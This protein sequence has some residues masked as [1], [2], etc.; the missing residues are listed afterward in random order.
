MSSAL[1]KF[2]PTLSRTK[3]TMVLIN[4]VRAG[5]NKMPTYG[6]NEQTP[7][8]KAIPFYA[9]WRARI[10]NGEEMKDKDEVIGNIIKIKNVKN[11]VGMPKR[12]AEIDLYYNTGFNPNNEYLDFT[13]DLGLV[14]RK[15]SWFDNEKWGLHVQG[16]EKLMDF[17]KQN[18]EVFN[19]C[20]NTVNESFTKYT[21]LDATI[22]EDSE[23]GEDDYD[24][25]TNEE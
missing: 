5:M 8:G 12:L 17:F 22:I 24:G 13:I 10:S 21:A 18:Q 11:K 20:K 9:S 3:T 14:E 19:E 2:N 7:G 4:Q 15:G 25:E 23:I 1:Q 6:P 16:R